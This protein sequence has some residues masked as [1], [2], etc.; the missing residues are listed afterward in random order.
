MIDVLPSYF[1]ARSHESL[2]L[3]AAA[4]F[5][6]LGIGL[7]SVAVSL[8]SARTHYAVWTSAPMTGAYAVFIATFVCFFCAAREVPFPLATK[9]SRRKQPPRGTAGAKASTAGAKASSPSAVQVPVIS[10]RRQR[11]VNGQDGTGRTSTPT[12]HLAKSRKR[13]QPATRKKTGSRSQSAIPSR[14]YAE[15][16]EVALTDL[17]S[18]TTPLDVSVFASTTA[19]YI[20][21]MSARIPGFYTG[22][23][24]NMFKDAAV[25]KGRAQVAECEQAAYAAKAKAAKISTRLQQRLD[26]ATAAKDLQATH[27]VWRERE[28]QQAAVQAK[29]DQAAEQAALVGI[30]IDACAELASALG[31]NLR[32]AEPHH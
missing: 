6:A 17:Q 26:A 7:I 2:W 16:I 32:K 8:D 31:I 11:S 18:V 29:I 22:E 30:R 19:Q 25:A 20:R 4:T 21:D 12:L 24:F 28:A 10:G 14:E 3:G 9:R 1:V 23:F 15:C 5:A 27:D 13:P